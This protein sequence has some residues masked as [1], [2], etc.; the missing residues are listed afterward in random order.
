MNEAT[1]EIITLFPQAI[2][3]TFVADVA[4][5]NAVKRYV[6]HAIQ[7][8]GRIDGFYN[9]A[10]TESSQ[11]N[12]TRRVGLPEEVAKIVAFL[13]S[14]ACSYVNGQIIAIDGGNQTLT[15]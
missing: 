13:L 7:T 5:D 8:Y 9:N 12:P 4:D 14:D 6:D 11:R 10:E 2:L 15:G 1:K 3:T